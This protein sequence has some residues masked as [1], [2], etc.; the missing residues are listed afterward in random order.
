MSLESHSTHP[1]PLLPPESDSAKLERH[2]TAAIEE[3]R[4]CITY[5][6][7]DAESRELL[8]H[9]GR[10]IKFLVDKHCPDIHK[11]NLP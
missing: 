8:Y 2:L 5:L 3:L 11:R 10:T 4:Q 1:R 7:N 9:A 6:G